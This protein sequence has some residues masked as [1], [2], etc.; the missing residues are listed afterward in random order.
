MAG[1]VGGWQ[2]VHLPA[3][4]GHKGCPGREAQSEG[5]GPVPMAAS[6]SSGG[7]HPVS[8]VS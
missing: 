1:R 5:L 3:A 2:G 8:R 6:P 4:E 7:G